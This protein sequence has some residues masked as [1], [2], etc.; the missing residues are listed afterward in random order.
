M[1]DYNS[2]KPIETSPVLVACTA[3]AAKR[4]PR[5]CSADHGSKLSH[6][7]LPS[8]EPATRPLPCGLSTSDH[9]RARPCRWKGVERGHARRRALPHMAHCA[10]PHGR[11][12][13]SFFPP[14]TTIAQ[15]MKQAEQCCLAR[16]FRRTYQ[17]NDSRSL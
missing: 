8:A 7:Y 15:G 9:A 17:L 10:F 4:S 11:Q 6:F 13:S 12:R 5:P 1:T 3:G 16:T 2:R 14:V